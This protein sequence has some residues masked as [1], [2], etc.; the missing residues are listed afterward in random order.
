MAK[1]HVDDGIADFNPRSPRGLR[2]QAYQKKIN[3]KAF[4]STQPK[5]AATKNQTSR[6][7]TDVISIHAAQEGCDLALSASL[8]NSTKFQS[9]QPKRAAT[10]PNKKAPT[11]K[12][13]QSTQPKRAATYVLL[14]LLSSCKISIHA[15]QEGCDF[16]GDVG[17]LPSIISIHAAQEGCDYIAQTHIRYGENFNPR[18]PRGL[19]PYT[20]DFEKV[21]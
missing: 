1:R 12:V 2:L 6:G 4:Q 7:S 18:S 11:I 3:A 20:F 8:L 21:N 10:L 19:R 17:A 14:S 16:D 5:R 13:F 15:A 9:T